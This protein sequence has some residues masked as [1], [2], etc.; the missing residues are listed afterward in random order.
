MSPT[1][2]TSRRSAHPR[3]AAQRAALVGGIERL[4]RL[5]RGLHSG[6][7]IL[8]DLA[9][10]LQQEA[11]ALAELGHLHLPTARYGALL[12]EIAWIGSDAFTHQAIR[13]QPAPRPPEDPAETARFTIP[14]SNGRDTYT[15]C[16]YPG[17]SYA[18]TC[19]RW[20]IRR[21]DCSHIGKAQ[22]NPT[23]YPYHPE[24]PKTSA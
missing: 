7:L 20:T 15:V 21:I 6:A 17:E 19:P 18:C 8:P 24:A 4:L 3:P 11:A 10:L 23:W 1:T 13:W 12:T 16:R 14:S 5:A 9:A 22:A 2:R